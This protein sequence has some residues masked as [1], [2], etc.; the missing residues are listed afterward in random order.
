MPVVIHPHVDLDACACVALSDVPLDAVRFLRA[1]A[2][3]VPPEL[4]AA[5]ILD[6]EMGEKGIKDADGARHAAALSMPEASDLLAGDLLSEIDEQDFQGRVERPRFSLGLILAGLRHEYG[7]AG[8]HG[9]TLDR[10]ILEV[11]VPVLRGLARLERSRFSAQGAAER[12]PVVQIGPW[13]FAVRDKSLPANSSLGNK[14][15]DSK[16]PAA[17][18]LDMALEA[19]GCVGAI[20]RDGYSLGITRYPGHSEPDLRRLAPHLPG[21]FVHSAGFLVCWGSRKAP[22]TSPPPLDTPQSVDAL[23][24]LLRS[25]LATK[26]PD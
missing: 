19:R 20:Y 13:I 4:A 26:V 16:A 22:A 17:I 14:A 12:I 6:H 8:L 11:M 24:D 21:W 18:G 25:E 10:A 23:I 1:D 15:A 5:R 9:E 2:G 7:N 3:D